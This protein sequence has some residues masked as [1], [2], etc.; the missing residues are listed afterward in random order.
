MPGS[1]ATFGSARAF[2]SPVRSTLAGASIDFDSRITSLEA[3]ATRIEKLRTISPCKTCRKFTRICQPPEVGSV[4][5]VSRYHWR[6]TLCVRSE[7]YLSLP[8]SLSSRVLVVLAP[9]YANLLQSLPHYASGTK[10]R[11]EH[12]I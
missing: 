6:D 12:Y 5:I 9:N 7:K 4:G 10:E 3:Q 11:R 1:R 2:Q 8:A